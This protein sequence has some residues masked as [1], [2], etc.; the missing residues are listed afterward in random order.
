MTSQIKHFLCVL[1][2]LCGGAFSLSCEKPAGS[3]G[4]AIKG[5]PYKIV[6][7][8]AMVTDI[9]RHV[10]GDKATVQGLLGEGVDPHLYKPTRDDVAAMMNADAVLYSGL[11]LEGKM[12]DSLVKLGREGK[13]VYAVTEL[14]DDKYL[15]EP[16]DQPGHPDPHVWMD[17]KAWIQ[18][19]QASAKALSELDPPNAG[20][21]DANAKKYIAELEKLDAYCKQIA[22]TVPQRSRVL[23]TAH[24]AFQYF[25][26]A[27]GFEVRGIQGIS[28]ESE[29]AI[30]DLNRL[31]N[32][33]VERDIKAVF[34]ESSVSEKNIKALIEGARSRGKEVRIGGQ[35]FS[36]AMGPAGTYEGTYIGMID[37]NVTT[38][39]RSLGGSAP[40]RGLNGKLSLSH[41]R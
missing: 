15:M 6:T 38:I 32:L 39:V 14:I 23:I 30:Q 3:S 12:A 36:D 25:G 24:D 11:M 10:A 16:A 18:C 27:Y 34:V 17:V 2:V 20:Y 41:G 1:C 28:T 5:Y 26:R 9:V 4:G 21:Y 33:I 8:V 19:V 37:H 7:T 31:V 29:G 40:E 13:K 22:A 35:L